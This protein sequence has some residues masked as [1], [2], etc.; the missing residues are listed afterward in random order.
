MITGAAGSIGSEIVRQ[1]YHYQPR[2]LV[3]LD[4]AETPMNQL[5]I[6]LKRSRIDMQVVT[7]YMGDV[8]RKNRIDE[9]FQE[10]K[11]NIVFHAAAYKGNF[12]VLSY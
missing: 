5:L 9:V 4:N 11:P 6:D 10:V 3:L 2:K 7:A 12:S 8:T 1:V